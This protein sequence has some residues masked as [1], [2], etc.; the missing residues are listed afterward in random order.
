MRKRI[1]ACG[2]FTQLSTGYAVYM[3]GLL[4]FLHNNGYDVIELA[5]ACIEG[6]RRLEN[7]PWKVIANIPHQSNTGALEKYNNFPSSE[8]GAWQFENIVNNF[9][10]DVVIDIRDNWHYEFQLR[11]PLRDYFSS[12]IMP[13][14]DAEPQNKSWLNF[15]SKADAVL[16]Y[17]QW[18]I[19]IMN[20]SGFKINT[21]GAT[22]PIASPEFVPYFGKKQDIK[23]E[24]GIGD[25]IVIGMVGRNQ[26]R[27]L[28]PNLFSAFSEVSKKVDNAV[29]LIHTKFPDRGW[30]IDEEIVKYNIADKVYITYVCNQCGTVKPSLYK[31][32]TG[33]CDK[34][35]YANSAVTSN[36][37][38]GVSNAEMVKLYNSMDLYVQWHTNE[39]YGIPAMEALACGV[40]IVG[41]DY[42]A[43]SEVLTLGGGYKITP[44]GFTQEIETGRKFAVPDDAE[45]TNYVYEFCMLPAQ[46][47]AKM[48]VIA[49]MHYDANWNIENS[50]KNWV[51]AIESV[52][53]KKSWNNPPEAHQI[54]QSFP[55]GMSN[56]DFA[57]W[58]IIEVLNK[59]E[60][61]G[62]EMHAR[63]L[64][65]LNDSIT[66]G[67]FG[68]MYY[69]E[70]NSCVFKDDQ[71][72]IPFS[73]SDAFNLFKTMAEI[74]NIWEQ[75][76][77]AKNESL[78]HISQ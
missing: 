18:G 29:L 17:T 36:S 50:Y 74:N 2:E 14:I 57:E 51:K 21:I 27:K 28:F 32:V 44:I 62:S 11:S 7:V 53:P 71:K 55:T 49:R 46:I 45:L 52:K 43:V 77:V 10:P 59:R 41:V 12:V 19:D 75:E 16:S 76:R 26:K 9:R 54:P 42:S 5:C 24:F 23:N 63:L 22:P 13:A 3:R 64:R 68:G 60:Y 4:T 61:I 15:Q 8:Y 20:D 39:G 40:P 65:D 56:I 35:G 33:Y 37:D 48:G 34:C 66:P 1:L 69:H 31:G 67:G 70:I 38:V 73:Q 72:Y 25:K 58:L 6:D 30:A 78:V 47:R